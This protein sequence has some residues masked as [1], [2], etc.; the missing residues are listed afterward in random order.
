MLGAIQDPQ[1]LL[2]KAV[3]QPQPIVVR[4]VILPHIQD[5]AFAFAEHHG[6]PDSLFLQAL[7]VAA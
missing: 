1:I 7:K 6:V 5:F 2:S 4:G 3:F